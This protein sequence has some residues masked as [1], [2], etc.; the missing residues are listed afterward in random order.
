MKN[1]PHLTAPAARTLV[2]LPAG[3]R[4]QVVAPSDPTQELAA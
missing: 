4:L 2:A 3:W 1:A